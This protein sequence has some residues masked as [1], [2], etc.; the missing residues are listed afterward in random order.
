MTVPTAN[1]RPSRTSWVIGGDT[2]TK[3]TMNHHMFTRTPIF[4]QSQLSLLTLLRVLI[5]GRPLVVLYQMSV[6]PRV[7]IGGG[8]N[9][10]AVARVLQGRGHDAVYRPGLLKARL[11]AAGAASM[12]HRCAGWTPRRFRDCARASG[13]RA[14]AGVC[15]RCATG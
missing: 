14:L 5:N 9:G 4:L 10:L 1:A 13:V 3:S 7:V 8:I 11:C 15:G 6:T 2:V 12:A